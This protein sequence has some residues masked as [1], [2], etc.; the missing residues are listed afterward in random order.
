MIEARRAQSYRSNAG[1]QLLKGLVQLL[2][3]AALPLVVAQFVPAAQFRAWALAWG[4]ALLAGY[5][6]F[7]LQTGIAGLTARLLAAGRPAAARRHAQACS[8][9]RRH[10]G[11]APR[12]PAPA[13]CRWLVASV[14]PGLEPGLRH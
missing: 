2:Q 5:L 7:G 10:R 9:G 3:G 11:R 12:L 1:A 13:W 6:D 8:L 4:V 14:F